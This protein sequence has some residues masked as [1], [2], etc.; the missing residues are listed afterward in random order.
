MNFLTSQEAGLPEV[1]AIYMSNSCPILP[2]TS[3]YLR[4]KYPW[5]GGVFVGEVEPHLI[6]VFPLPARCALGKTNVL[7]VWSP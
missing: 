7:L 3:S 2:D 5:G 6:P 1:G 4:W